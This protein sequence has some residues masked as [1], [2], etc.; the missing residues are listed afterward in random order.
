VK[1]KVILK[2]K[3][4]PNGWSICRL[5]DLRPKIN[6]GF[7]SGKH[8]KDGKGIPH[9]RPMNI[10]TLGHIESLVV[11]YVENNSKDKLK[12]NDVLFNNTNSP[13][14]LGKTALISNDT[15]W[16]YSNH[17]TRIRLDSSMIHPSWIAIYLHKLFLDGYYKNIAKNHINQSSIN[18]DVL[19]K[20]IPIILAPFNEQKRIVSKIIK[21]FLDLD[22]AKIL[23]ENTQSKLVP[24]RQSLLKSAF[25]GKF[26]EKWRMRNPEKTGEVLFQKIQKQRKNSKNTKK[27]YKTKNIF[28][29]NV[30][31]QWHETTLIDVCDVVSGKT[32]KNI[33]E[34]T[35]NGTIPF[36]KVSDMNNP[37]N[38]L[39]MNKSGLNLENHELK[40]LKLSVI[41]SGTVIF[42]KRGGAILTNKKRIL[43][44]DSCF[45]LN[46]MGISPILILPKFIYFWFYRIDLK[47]LSDGS[48]VPQINHDDIEPLQF[49]LPSLEEQKIIVLQLEREFSLIDNIEKTTQ[50]ML[51]Q[52][53][54]LRLI[55]LKHAFEG[56][57][58][59]QD[60][61]DESASILLENI[62]NDKL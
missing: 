22:S 23:L 18:T 42:P 11:K 28:S 2:S 51:D 1:S 7:A 5:D 59:S 34:Y 19:S 25:E 33:G 58:L 61:K 46:L 3:K 26:T 27:S 4:L 12:K 15:D 13:K 21:L 62:Q 8:N 45:D 57:L 36:F 47:Q 52:L 9:I 48:N 60:P 24:F 10:N 20:E 32:P 41:K 53:D 38:L 14:L 16:A 30:P 31:K 49:H 17:M 55:I 54:V 40:E 44:K 29:H 39:F 37:D 6:S 50:L 56:K 35:K 43:K